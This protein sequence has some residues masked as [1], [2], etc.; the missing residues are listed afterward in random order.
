[1][2]V[3]MLAH[4]VHCLLRKLKILLEICWFVEREWQ[5]VTASGCLPAA[6]ASMLPSGL[7]DSA[8]TACPLACSH[9]YSSVCS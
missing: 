6:T 4:E 2:F 5:T 3:I 8:R 1:M 9:D 7:K